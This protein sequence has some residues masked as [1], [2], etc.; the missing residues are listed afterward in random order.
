[1]LMRSFSPAQDQGHRTGERPSPV[2]SRYVNGGAWNARSII[3]LILFWRTVVFLC[4]KHSLSLQA[5]L[6]EKILVV[7]W[8][9]LYFLIHL[10][11]HAAVLPYSFILLQK[12][13]RALRRISSARFAPTSKE[14]SR[15]CS[16][17][18]VKWRR[19]RR[20][21]KNCWEPR[22]VCVCSRAYCTF[23]QHNFDDI[24][25][26]WSVKCSQN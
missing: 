10:H 21:T 11:P 15:I 20:S 25:K 26:L 19:R 2:K 7:T 16:L 12:V 8:N 13:V 9:V 3:H 5:N 14:S 17:S 24:R 4:A 6:S 1:M 18:W 23:L 22:F